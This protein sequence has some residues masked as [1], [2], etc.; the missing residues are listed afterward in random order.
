MNYTEEER[1]QKHNKNRF[2]KEAKEESGFNNFSI[3]S[4]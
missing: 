2:L 1:E 4:E 3:L